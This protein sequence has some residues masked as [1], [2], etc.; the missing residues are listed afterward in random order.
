VETQIGNAIDQAAQAVGWSYTTISFNAANPATLQAALN[1]A[2]TKQPAI[3]AEIAQPS[4]VFGAATIAA[5]AKAGV[6]IL[7]SN[8]PMTVTKTLVGPV[9]GTRNAE[10][11]GKILADWFIVNSKG[12]GKVLLESVPAYPVLNAIDNSFQSTVKQNCSDCTVDRVNFTVVQVQAGQIVSGVVSQ[13]SAH[14][15]LNYLMFDEGE[16]ATGINS[17]LDAAGLSNIKIGGFGLT[18]E[19]ANALRS[20]TQS[21]WLG[22]DA[23]YNGYCIM[24]LSLRA[25]EHAPLTTNCDAFPTQL[26]TKSTVGTTS[27]IYVAVPNELQKFEKLWKVSGN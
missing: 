8:T 22:L 4:S 27:T 10:V 14:R 18:A 19:Q 1:T 7:V 15:S 2:L 6:P 26:L 20:G 24:D 3:V 16:F 9:N 23:Q 11:I 25:V 17:A 21:A 13:L 5:Y 12:T